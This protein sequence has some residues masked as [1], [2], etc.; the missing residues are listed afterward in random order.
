[1]EATTTDQEG[2]KD[3]KPPQTSCINVNP[4]SSVQPRDRDALQ[5]MCTSHPTPFMSPV[6][7]QFGSPLEICCM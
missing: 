4:I 6:C 3:Y 7:L 5:R 1:M 2:N